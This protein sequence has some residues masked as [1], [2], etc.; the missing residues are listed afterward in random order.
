MNKEL[1][2][3]LA[4]ITNER[5]MVEMIDNSSIH[6]KSKF[7]NQE[8]RMNDIYNSFIFYWTKPNWAHIW[9]IKN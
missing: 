3:R 2:L 8:T 4:K 7:G 6:K 9:N 5:R 1:K